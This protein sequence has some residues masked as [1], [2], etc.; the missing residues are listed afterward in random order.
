MFKKVFLKSIFETFKASDFTEDFLFNQRMRL[1]TI[2][3]TILQL[4]C[5]FVDFSGIKEK[6]TSKVI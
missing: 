3:S 5:I 2:N 1:K 4:F 6:K